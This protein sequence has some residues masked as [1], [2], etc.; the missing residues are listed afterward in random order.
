MHNIIL[1]NNF[2]YSNINAFMTRLTME[3]NKLG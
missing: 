2:E 1:Y 3:H